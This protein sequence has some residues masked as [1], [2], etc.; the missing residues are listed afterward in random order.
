MRFRSEAQEAA[1][2]ELLLQRG[3]AQPADYGRLL[4]KLLP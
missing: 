2:D 3:L 4:L 1:P